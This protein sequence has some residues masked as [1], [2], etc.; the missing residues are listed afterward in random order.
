MYL[1]NIKLKN[2]RNYDELF[3][4]LSPGINIL[5]GDNA[6]GKT[7]ILESIYFLALTK[8]HRSLNDLTLIK[9]N[10]NF[11]LLSTSCVVNENET[12][13]EISISDKGKKLKQDNNLVKIIG[14]YVSNLKVIIFFPEDLDLIKSSPDIR[15]HYINTQISQLDKNYFKILS[16]Y[17]KLL[18]IRNNLLKE[19]LKINYIDNNYLDIITNYIVEKSCY[20]YFYRNKYIK[21]INMYINNIFKD[22]S[23]F[24]NFRIE[25]KNNFII[26][27]FELNDLKEII[28]EKFNNI[29]EIEKKAGTT[30]VGPHRDDIE[31]YLNDKN[32]KQFGSQGQQRMAVLSLKLSEIEI[33]KKY[34][35]DNPIL[36]L[37]DVF[38]ELDDKKKNAL[39]KYISNDIQTIITTTELSNLDKTIINQAKLIHISA[40]KVIEE[41]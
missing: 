34:N 10:E 16:E 20:I 17:N 39:L 15:R 33:F 29:L 21:K 40:G 7:N 32:L 13:L 24:D 38:S 4:N 1:K 27:S 37:D 35:N 2:F 22:I 41:E 30:L 6:Q 18:K 26:N 14:E 36:L 3:L 23:G 11:S 8:S 25:Y 31:F 5:Y 19:Y 28:R 12:N 9:N